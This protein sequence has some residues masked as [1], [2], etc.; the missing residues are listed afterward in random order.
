[1]IARHFGFVFFFVI[2]CLVGFF[3]VF[4]GLFFLS[5]NYGVPFSFCLPV[6]CPN[7]YKVCDAEL[8]RDIN[9]ELN[10]YDEG[11]RMR[12]IHFETFV[13]EDD[14]GRQMK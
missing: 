6:S 5:S 14:G 13:K 9:K 12:R 10:N 2:V 1:M 4:F 8:A 11:G 3:L 7:N